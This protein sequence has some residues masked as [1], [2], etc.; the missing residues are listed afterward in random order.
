MRAAYAPEPG[1]SI[2]QQCKPSTLPKAANPRLRQT[3]LGRFHQLCASTCQKIERNA[4]FNCY[5]LQ[6]T[7]SQ[8]PVSF[9]EPQPFLVFAKF[10]Q[11]PFSTI[12]RI[13]HCSDWEK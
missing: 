7:L 4:N 6:A 11:A 12:F 1:A 10:C 9:L 3:Q 2:R 13:T 8:T 5:P